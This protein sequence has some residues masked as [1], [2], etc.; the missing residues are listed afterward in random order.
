MNYREV[1]LVKWADAH[2]APAEWLDPEDL[3]RSGELFVYSVGHLLTV[4]RGGKE[5]HV[6][7]AQ[8]CTSEGMVDHVIYIPNE[9]VRKVK[10]LIRP[11]N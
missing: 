9:M 10:V 4:G 8:S 5:G 2:S 7:I 3:E 11:R 1:V 6:T